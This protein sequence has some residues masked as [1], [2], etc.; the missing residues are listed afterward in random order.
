MIEQYLEI[1]FKPNESKE[2]SIE[3][4]TFTIDTVIKN[5]CYRIALNIALLHEID[6]LYI[7]SLVSLLSDYEDRGVKFCLVGVDSEIEAALNKAY[8]NDSIAMYQQRGQFF[9]NK[10]HKI[11]FTH[12]MGTPID[13]LSIVDISNGTD[14]SDNPTCCAIAGLYECSQCHSTEYFMKGV[15]F[16][17]C[18]GEGCT[19]H[20]LDWVLIETIF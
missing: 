7:I 18:T 9:A 4:L 3:E 8:I 10:N 20:L 1:I 13:Q 14:Y 16:E 19:A 12:I 11:A 15:N 6:Y 17:Q 5:H 2:S